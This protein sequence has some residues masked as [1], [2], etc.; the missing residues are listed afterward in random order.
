MAPR[1]Q[2][3]VLCPEPWPALGFSGPGAWGG[4]EC[5]EP[6]WGP[7]SGDEEKG[8]APTGGKRGTGM[9][10]TRALPETLPCLPHLT[11]N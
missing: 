3:S 11:L 1:G 9:W 8:M 10:G 4:L 2:L 6:A 5:P 7:H